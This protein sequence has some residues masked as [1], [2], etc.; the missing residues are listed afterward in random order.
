MVHYWNMQQNDSTFLTSGRSRNNVFA[1][2]SKSY[3][4]KKDIF[5]FFINFYLENFVIG[6]CLRIYV[7]ASCDDADCQ[8]ERNR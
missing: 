6:F 3:W 2:C 7:I 4:Q 8:I 1:L 5:I